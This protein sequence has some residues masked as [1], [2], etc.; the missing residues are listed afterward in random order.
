MKD[1]DCVTKEMNE[2]KQSIK[3]HIGRKIH[4]DVKKSKSRWI[5][6]FNGVIDGCFANVFTI[7]RNNG[8]YTSFKYVDVFVSRHCGQGIKFVF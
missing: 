2:I 4:V 6:S 1:N 3:E 5:S 7:K 8:T